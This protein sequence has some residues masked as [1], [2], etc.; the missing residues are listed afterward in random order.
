MKVAA[1]DAT[2]DVGVGD[3]VQSASGANPIHGHDG[4]KP[5]LVAERRHRSQLGGVRVGLAELAPFADVLEVHPHAEA[6]TRAGEDERTYLRPTLDLGPG[7]G[8]Q[9]VGV[10][11]EG[12]EPL[13]S[14]ERDDGDA[15][16]DLELQLGHRRSSLV[17]TITRVAS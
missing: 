17:N 2:H 6:P 7:G 8:K 11:V 15:V 14:V 3:E 13:G 5:D 10:G 9:R 4:R 16:S 1:V 12:V